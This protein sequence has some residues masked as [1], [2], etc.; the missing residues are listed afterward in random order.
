MWPEHWAYD[1]GASAIAFDPTLAR[2][3]LA[4]AGFSSRRLRFSC[5]VPEGFDVVERLALE[6]QHALHTVGVDLT[7][8][9]VTLAELESRMAKGQ[10]DSVLLDLLS[11]PSL[12][13][14]YAFWH[15]R[16]EGASLN[17]FGYADARVDAALDAVRR[18]GG[19]S[20]VRAS[21]GQ[22]QRAF[23]NNPPG[24]FIAWSER[25]RA[26]S[27]RIEVPTATGLGPFQPFA[28]WR[29]RRPDEVKAG[30]R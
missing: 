7:F 22:L 20:V 2:A 6:M 17:F 11:G 16:G 24:I 21:T 29:V 8:E 13:R 15:S 25:S 27:R 9:S 26:V 28:K 19:E 4:S 5:L 14:L 12:S 23:A 18:N 3:A 30:T 10:F 1:Q